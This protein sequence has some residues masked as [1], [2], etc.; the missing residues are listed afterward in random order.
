MLH[1]FPQSFSRQKFR[2][3]PNI[4]QYAE[5]KVIHRPALSKI[6]ATIGPA[7]EQIQD[8]TPVVQ[9]GLTVMRINFSH[10]T[11]DEANLR[12]TNL[13]SLAESIPN[14]ADVNLR[15]IMLDTQ[16]PEI[17]T[18]VFE[19]GSKNKQFAA[20]HIITLTTNPEFRLKQTEDKLWISYPKL[21]DTVDEGTSI[22]LDDGAIEVMVRKIDKEKGEITCKV[23]NAGTLGNR[24][25][26]PL[27]YF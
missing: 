18:G 13:R 8:L 16:G 14:L 3:H 21:V 12:T 10:A 24:K 6:V 5:S 23:V 17:R 22:L 26:K 9:A 2:I 20:Q 27:K 4:R 15:S 11:F 19:D 7:S 25:G 1:L